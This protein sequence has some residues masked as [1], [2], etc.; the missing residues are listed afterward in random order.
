MTSNTEAFVWVWLP[1]ETL[2]VVAGRLFD[3]GNSPQQF[4]FTYGRSY[5]A[6][7]HAI[8]LSPFE[9]PLQ[10]GVQETVGMSIMPSCL[11][12]AGPDAW[13]RRILESRLVETGLNELDYLLLSGSDRIG[14]LDFQSSS[15][16]YVA[17]E[18]SHPQ[19]QELIRAAE[20]VENHQILPAEL[21]NAL[22]RGTSVG[23]ARPKAILEEGPNR[24]IAK[25]SSMADTYNAVKAEFIAMTLASRCGLDVASVSLK[26]SLHKDVILVKRFDRID[27]ANGSCRRQMLSALSLLQLDE[28]EARYA[29][30]IDLAD[31]IRQRFTRP[32][33][34][35]HELFQR[36]TFNILIGNTDDHAR[37]HAAFWDGKELTL[38][39]AYDI[40]PQPRTGGEASQA[41]R[42]DG[43][44]DN[45]S[46]LD[47][48]RSV[49]D[50]FQL[51]T[52]DA[53]A[54]IEKMIATIEAK[55]ESV[56][57]QAELPEIE[58]Q[59]LWQSAVFNPFCF[60]NWTGPK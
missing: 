23:G 28:M 19:L 50:R 51:S 37:N 40:C 55:W 18:M 33:K 25:F 38:T 42:I 27:T 13:G 53:T 52:T 59:R 58:R 2:P 4:S 60:E 46:T 54:L 29:S 24:Y 22:L 11:R 20:M 57:D 41:M 36:I 16:Q 1:G 21:E 9:L 5:L 56:C 17:R 45:L 49:C 47:N 31:R 48:L 30:Y 35:L 10:A 15:K 44:R 14:A 34:T 7:E 8:P 39:P 26:R 12:D 6:R 43:N 3:A 32:R